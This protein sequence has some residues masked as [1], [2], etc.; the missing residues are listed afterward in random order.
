V[1]Y[2]T[3]WNVGVTKFMGKHSVKLGMDWRA[4]H[5]DAITSQG[6]S[7]FG[8]T[9]GFTSQTPTKTVSGTGGGLATM[10]LGYP[11]SG[12]IALGT[13]FYD[14]VHYWALFVQDDFRVSSKLTLNI[15]FRGE[16]ESNPAERSNKFAIDAD[17]T[18]T[19]PLEAGIP[20]LVLKSAFRYAGSGNPSHAGNPLGFK[21]GP[22]AGFAYKID[23]KTAIRGGYGIFWIPQSFSAQNATGYSQTTNIVTSTNNNYTPAATL[24][25]PYPNGLL[26]PVGNALGTATAIGQ[27]VSAI[28]PGNR[29]PGYVEQFSFDV[30]RQIDNSDVVSAGYI[31]SHTLKQP[32]NMALNELNPAYYALGASLNSPQVANPFYGLA[33]SAVTLGSSSTISRSSLLV[34]YPEYT[35]V[36]LATPMGRSIYYAF[37]AKIQRRLS[38]GLTLLATYTWSRN[39]TLL[40]QST[41]S[42]PQTNFAAVIPQEWA[43]RPPTSRT[44]TR[45]P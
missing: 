42:G 29:S 11:S 37:Y 39:M 8:F 16:H 30:Q 22:R 33:P 38:H 4:L 7:S 19:N 5:S 31:G 40:S 28:D 36:T 25:N 10:L 44:T 2:S 14:Y 12:N 17:L 24:D 43:A 26:Q 35:T 9:S 20:S 41:T 27:A 34:Q 32:Y 13:N 23:S 15:G 21:L 6:P 1:Y 45:W 18:A 3:S